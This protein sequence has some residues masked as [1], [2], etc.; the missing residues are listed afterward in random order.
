MPNSLE[1]RTH[2]AGRGGASMMRRTGEDP[3]TYVKG[4][5]VMSHP[6]AVSRVSDRLLLLIT[7]AAPALSYLAAFTLDNRRTFVDASY[8]TVT[9]TQGQAVVVAQIFGMAAALI[10]SAHVLIRG[11]KAGQQPMTWLALPGVIILIFSYLRHDIDFPSLLGYGVGIPVLLAA[12]VTTIDKTAVRW[13]GWFG[14]IFVASIWLVTLFM[15]SEALKPCRADK[16][17]LGGSLL[18]GY[19]SHENILGLF[20]AFL[21]PALAFLPAGAF[22]WGITAMLG[23]VAATGSRTAYITVAVTFLIAIALRYPQMRRKV[24]RRRKPN[25]LQ[26]LGFV[27]LVSAIVASLA[28]ILL[29]AAGL[30]DRGAIWS[31]IRGEL[32]S[33]LLWGSGSGIFVD[34]YEGSRTTWLIPHAHSEIGHLLL[35]GGLF[36]TI[37]F[38]IGMAHLGW[39]AWRYNG[40]SPI[41]FAVGP[42]LSFATEVVW[43]YSFLDSFMWT[44]F[45]TIALVAV[46]SR[47][48][49]TPWK[50]PESRFE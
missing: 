43:S 31:L 38:A 17:G 27:P 28:F 16:C 18:V 7:A 22:F 33:A 21:V 15:P 26:L 29:P 50:T 23:T 42:A 11:I 4:G 32:S 34:A 36:A 49:P 6:P 46:H 14:L 39:A 30:T 3:L 1:G 8:R 9:V 48:R 20:V 13:L 44:L 37:P 25:F 24:I 35:T 19:M 47:G 41:V 12:S 2:L 40:L 5:V 10:L 45:I